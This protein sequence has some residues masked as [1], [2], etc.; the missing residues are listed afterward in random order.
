M[1][2]DNL[3]HDGRI[4]SLEAR[5]YL[6]TYTIT[7]QA[8]LDDWVNNVQGKDYT[9]VLIAP[10][11]N[12]NLSASINLAERGTRRIEGGTSLGSLVVPQ[13]ATF[14]QTVSTGLT[15][16][17]AL[18]YYASA[19]SS[20]TSSY[21]VKN[22]EI[23]VKG[24]A[25]ALN[26]YSIIFR[27]IN[28]TGVRVHYMHGSFP[29]HAHMFN[30]CQ[31][32]DNCY[33]YIG[34]ASGTNIL[35]GF[36]NCNRVYSCSGKVMP[37]SA[38]DTMQR[39]FS[40]CTD[41][42]AS[43]ADDIA[44]AGQTF[45]NCTFDGNPVSGTNGANKMLTYMSA[46]VKAGQYTQGSVT[47]TDLEPA[48]RAYTPTFTIT[49]QT[50]FDYWVNGTT[51]YDYTHVHLAPTENYNF[52]LA[53][54]VDL[55]VRKTKRF[56]ANHN[57]QI[58]GSYTS[59]RS[60]AWAAHFYNGQGGYDCFIDNIKFVSTPSGTDYCCAFSTCNNIYNCEVR[61]LGSGA[62][63][64]YALHLCN[65]IHNTHAHIMS[66]KA[67]SAAF[68]ACTGVYNCVAAGRTNTPLNGDPVYGFLSCKKCYGNNMV[69][70]IECVAYSDTQSYSGVAAD[71][72]VRGG[73]NMMTGYEMYWN[74]A[75][76]TNNYFTLN[77]TLWS[78]EN[79]W[80]HVSGGKLRLVLFIDT[81]ATITSGSQ[82]GTFANNL[83]LP[84][85]STEVSQFYTSVYKYNSNGIDSVACA[86]VLGRNAQI[87]TP[88]G[89]TL[90]SGGKFFCSLEYF[91]GQ[92]LHE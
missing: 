35:A 37:A 34:G 75:N 23:L 59:S 91:F 6:P 39:L 72:S 17:S 19:P 73:R 61:Y 5:I 1:A 48:M 36:N 47:F 89:T 13:G 84:D 90:S 27:C 54:Q 28:V 38:Q 14:A 78:L 74:G 42:Y 67:G 58:M 83:P 87:F 52:Y 33:A 92:S 20:D 32:L 10:S 21:F 49:S 77:T 44:F 76:V 85:T 86:S 56:T 60:L 51:G 81:V 70:D 29:N 69:S 24:P 12:I 16:H 71:A 57:A 79:V 11:V 7:V 62:Q 8:D 50:Q 63:T 88:S 25:T 45:D 66:M 53:T 4:R 3:D 30:Y 65:N 15:N 68:G 40:W 41:V 55:N 82:I 22:L 31:N 18:F 43:G 80:L 64:C 46:P 26:P 9:H 2:Y